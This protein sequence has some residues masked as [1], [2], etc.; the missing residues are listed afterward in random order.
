MRLIVLVLVLSVMV[1]ACD[2]ERVYEYDQEFNDRA[3]NTADSARFEF[4]VTDARLKYNVL[5]NVRNS[6][7]YPWSRLF[8]QYTLQDSM[9]VQL[10]KK[11][12]SEY[13]F[14]VKTG[15]PTGNSGLGDLYDHQFPIVKNYTFRHPGKYS[16]KL[17]QFMRTDTLRGIYSVGI[18][19]ERALP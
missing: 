9:G 14:E 1:V 18:R 8:I 16:V 6:L 7:D 17:E 12:L 2:S 10:E 3:W 15:K 5:C 4:V 11:L 13:L 19:V